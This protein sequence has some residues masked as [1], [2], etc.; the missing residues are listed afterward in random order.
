MVWNSTKEASAQCLLVLNLW[1]SE[2]LLGLPRLGAQGA[3]CLSEA[4][5]SR[6]FSRCW[7]GGG[8]RRGRNIYSTNKSFVVVY[9][10]CI[11]DKKRWPRSPSRHGERR[12]LLERLV[13]H[14]GVRRRR[15]LG[16]NQNNTTTNS[17]TNNDDKTTN[18]NNTNTNNKQ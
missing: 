4:G 2:R 14:L 10:R 18:N 9:R 8:G 16:T 15:V 5:R 17:N 12:S 3:E 13:A 1:D 6:V 11:Q 7:Q